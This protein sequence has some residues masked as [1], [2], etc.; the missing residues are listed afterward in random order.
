MGNVKIVNDGT[1]DVESFLNE[2]QWF[3][4]G[5]HDDQVD[6]VSGATQM[7][8]PEEVSEVY[9]FEEVVSISPI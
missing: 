6:A 5:I 4:E 7:F 8:G 1:W 9:V 2:C 3:P